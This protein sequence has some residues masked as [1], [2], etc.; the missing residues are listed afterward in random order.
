[1]RFAELT[2]LLQVRLLPRMALFLKKIKIY[3]TQLKPYALLGL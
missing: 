3:L 2:I 1:V